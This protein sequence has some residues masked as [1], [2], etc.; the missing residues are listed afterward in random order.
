MIYL[1]SYKQWQNN[2]K[3][4]VVPK[5]YIIFDATED[6]D[7]K[8]NAYTQAVTMDALNPPVKLVKLAAKE[9][10]IDDI[11]DYNK[12]EKL[13][14]EYFKG[15]QFTNALLATVAGQVESD[16]N[17]FIVFRNKAFKYYKN[18]IKNRFEKLFPVDFE[19]VKILK[20]DYDKKELKKQLKYR[21]SSE[22]VQDLKAF[23][24]SNEKEMEKKFNKKKDK[25]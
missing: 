7:A 3:K 24:K 8:M 12:I 1:M 5:D 20:D 18:K 17:I 13:E 23:L 2:K 11:I 22:E 4:L 9:D 19:F 15:D 14:K 25:K 21:F 6:D 16:I 10:N